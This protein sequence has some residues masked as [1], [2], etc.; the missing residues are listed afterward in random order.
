MTDPQAIIDA[1]IPD[2]NDYG[3]TEEDWKTEA[4]RLRAREKELREA[5]EPF[6]GIAH[7]YG[8][9]ADDVELTLS[10]KH[11]QARPNVEYQ[12]HV[13]DFRRARSA[14]GEE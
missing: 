10:T 2:P 1:L 4:L 7:G 6:V 11:P 13:G 3:K 8:D 12:L 5:L 9:C 14:Y